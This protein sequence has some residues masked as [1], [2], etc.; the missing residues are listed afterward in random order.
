MGYHR[1][2]NG[3]TIQGNRSPSLHKFNATGVVGRAPQR[4]ICGPGQCPE[5]RGR[6]VL[7]VSAQA[8][9]ERCVPQW[10]CAFFLLGSEEAGNCAEQ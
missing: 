7:K 9:G 8:L 4:P 10:L 2:A 3:A 6:S 5:V 1:L